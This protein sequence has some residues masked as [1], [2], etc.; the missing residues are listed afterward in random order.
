M[1]AYKSKLEDLYLHPAGWLSLPTGSLISKL[2]LLDRNGWDGRGMARGSDVATAW[3]KRVGWRLPSE[4]EYQLL[5]A[6]PETLHIEPMTIYVDRSNAHLMAS[7]EWCQRHDREVWERLDAAG[8]TCQPVA[9]FGKHID[10]DGDIIGWDRLA[11]TGIDF[12]QNESPA[13]RGYPQLDYATGQ[14]VVI[15]TNAEN[16]L[17]SI[18]FRQANK[19]TPGWRYGRPLGVCLHTS[20]N[21]EHPNGAEVLQ[22][23]ASLRTTAVSWHY[24]VDNN[25]ITQSVR[26]TQRAAAAGP[27]ND[28][29]IHIEMFGRAGQGA[30]GWADAY[31]VAQLALTSRLVAALCRRYQAPLRRLSV[32]ELIAYDVP[33][34]IG[35][36]DVSAACALA[37]KRNLKRM[38][39]F[40]GRTWR[41]TN[42]G[43]PGPTFPWDMFLA[44]C[45]A[46]TF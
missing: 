18:P 15:P 2:P 11:G 16:Y 43:D 38:P 30:V 5:H 29:W 32:D 19:A 21:T 1:T 3:A 24:A 37:R 31:S 23:T 20:E 33:G 41:T 8:F 44:Q 10:R 6:A 45:Q 40:D 26:L 28:R 36:S 27:G 9:N 46:Q 7:P 12:I 39:W 25:S 17:D 35:H 14:H 4:E 13:H 42:H 22:A 34:V